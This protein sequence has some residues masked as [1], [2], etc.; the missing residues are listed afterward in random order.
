MMNPGKPKPDLLRADSI[1]FADVFNADPVSGR[2]TLGNDRYVMF[3]AEAVGKMRR[4]LIDNLGWEVARGILER[5]GY[6]SG[7]NDARQLGARYS[8]PSDE[9]WLRAGPRLHFLEGM[10]KVRVRELD[11]ARG[12]RRFRMKGDWIESYEAEQHLKQYGVGSRPVCWSLEGYATGYASEFFGEDIVCFEVSC[13]GK[14]DPVCSFELRPSRE[15]GGAALPMQEMLAAVRFTERFDRCLRS[16]S[17]M[18]CELEQSSLDAIVTTDARGMIT[19]CSQGGSE[20]LG[21][22]PGEAVGRP[23]SAF[24]ARGRA[25]AAR[26]ME[27]LRREGRIRYYLTDIITAGGRKTPIA[28]AASAI[29]NALGHVVGTIGVAHNLTEIRRLEDE[30]AA[31]N[32]FMANILQDSADAIITM[33]PDGT[34]TSWNRGA[35]SIFGYPADEV[36]GRSIE[37]IVP[38]DLLR[39]QRTGTDRAARQELTGAVRNYQTERMTKDGRR[40]Q[41]IFTRTAIRDETGRVVGSSAVLK[42]VTTFRNLERQL[43]DAEHLATLGELSAGLAHEIKNPLAG[44]KGAIDVIRDSLPVNRPAPGR[45]RGRVARGE[46]DRQDRAGPAELCQAEAPLAQRHRAPGGGAEAGRHGAQVPE[47]RRRL[48]P[49]S[50]S[51]G[52][53]PVSRGTKRSSNRCC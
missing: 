4:E 32:R 53:S 40:L 37:V 50:S 39:G 30:L 10:V 22:L 18:G 35:E 27:R 42:D 46:P 2:I 24:Y 9:E 15:W 47:D 36:L 49:S 41:V 19:S 23:V 43:A 52:T 31:K 16:I 1:E 8:W 17:E 38:A 28:L 33:D 12:E 48:D 21:L 44:I 13:R 29:K 45:A 11:F 25:E 6:Q 5:V 14:G 26:L 20:L 3:D 7:R 34:I 51:P